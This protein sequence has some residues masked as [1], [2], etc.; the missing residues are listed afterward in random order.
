M[1]RLNQSYREKGFA[2]GAE[3]PDHVSVIL[4]FLAGGYED[5]FS[6]VLQNE[7]LKPAV[8]KMLAVFE[9]NSGN[10]YR[11]VLGG[12]A[13]VLQEISMM[14]SMNSISLTKDG[15]MGND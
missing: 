1:A 4:R 9:E 3:L 5:E 6:Q 8:E 15:G 12:L 10:P 11:Q 7:G 2:P 13:L 14:S